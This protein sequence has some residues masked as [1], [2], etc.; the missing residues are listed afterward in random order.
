MEV[1]S[2]SEEA[3]NYHQILEFFEM[4]ANLITTL[5]RWFACTA[6]LMAMCRCRQHHVIAFRCSLFP[7]GSTKRRSYNLILTLEWICQHAVT[8]AS[9]S[10]TFSSICRFLADDWSTK[11][12]TEMLSSK[13]LRGKILPWQHEELSCLYENIVQVVSHDVIYWSYARMH[14]LDFH[15]MCLWVAKLAIFDCCWWYRAIIVLLKDTSIMWLFLLQS[16][17]KLC[18]YDCWWDADFKMHI[19]NAG[20]R[21]QE[22]CIQWCNFVTDHV[23]PGGNAIASVCPSIRLIPLYLWNWL[24][25]TLIFCMFLG[26]YHGSQGLKLKFKVKG[27]CLICMFLLLVRRSLSE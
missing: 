17:Y 21:P 24:T 7:T 12:F 5:A 23:S 6:E 22:V 25:S 11:L 10:E 20:H 13:V 26:H 27:F 8:A 15:A 19:S 14:V 16:W 4:C 3:A 9:R 18:C 1:V 2:D